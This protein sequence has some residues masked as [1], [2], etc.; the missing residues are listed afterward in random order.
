LGQIIFVTISPTCI[1]V[2]VP[3]QLSDDVTAAIFAEGTSPAHCTVTFAG[4]VMDGGVSSNTVIVCI[5]VAVLP[6]RSVA[7]Y[8]LAIVN[9]LAQV[10][11]V[12]TSPA[13]ASRTAP[14]Q[15]SLAMTAVVLAAG[16]WLAHCTVIF[17][18]HVMDGG[19]LSKTVMVCAHVAE[20]PHS[21]VA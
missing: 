9:L 1:T 12:I 21:S 6:H 15:L 17:A 14:P 4:Q 19:M 5:Q 18:G 7:L 2:V 20:L 16:T 3:P 11:F 13:C 10:M 8:V